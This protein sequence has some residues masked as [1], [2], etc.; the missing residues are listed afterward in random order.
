MQDSQADE[1]KSTVKS[2]KTKQRQLV[3]K[4]VSTEDP[5]CKRVQVMVSTLAMTCLYECNFCIM[6]YFFI[7]YSSIL[8]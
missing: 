6:F 3:K 8:F 1:G 5:V 4:T 2:D 7:S